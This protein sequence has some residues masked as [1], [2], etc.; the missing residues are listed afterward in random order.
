[1]ETQNLNAKQQ[2]A[3]YENL[4][5]ECQELMHQQAEELKA[6]QENYERIEFQNQL[7]TSKVEEL[8]AEL[9]AK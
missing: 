6:Y 3:D 8:N 9:E 4:E 7:L 2:E 5:K 1:M